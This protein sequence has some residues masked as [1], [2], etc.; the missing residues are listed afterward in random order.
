MIGQSELLL[1]VLQHAIG[2]KDDAYRL[3]ALEIATSDDET[4]SRTRARKI[5]Q[6]GLESNVKKTRQIMAWCINENGARL[7]LPQTMREQA[8]TILGLGVDETLLHKLMAKRNE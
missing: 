6:L 1:L 8:H 7:R 4:A 5:L 2:T 3:A